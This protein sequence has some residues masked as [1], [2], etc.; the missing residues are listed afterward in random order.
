MSIVDNF[1]NAWKITKDAFGLLGK[2]KDLLTPLVV[3]LIINLA[4]FVLALLFFFITLPNAGVA[5]YVIGLIFLLLTT[6][7]TTFFGAAL[8]WMIYE[9]YNKKD[10][11]LG[12]G[13]KIAFK[14]FLDIIW[15]TIV[16][17]LISLLVGMLRSKDNNQNFIAVILKNVFAGIIEKAWDILRHFILPSMILSSNNFGQAFKEIPKLKNHLPETLVGGFAFDLVLGPIHFI[18]FLVCLAIGFL[19]SLISVFAGLVVGIG[20]FVLLLILT[21]LVYQYVKVSYFTLMYID[22]KKKLKEPLLKL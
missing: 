4:L 3:A 13:M 5:F 19:L 10:T 15:Y 18:E 17:F 2:D 9:V 12:R 16:T 11:H 7:V 8:T 14:N 6:F 22:L 1:K 21:N 20:L